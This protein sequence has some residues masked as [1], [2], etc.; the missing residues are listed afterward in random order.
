MNYKEVEYEVFL[1]NKDICKIRNCSPA[2]AT[3]ILKRI[4]LLYE[5]DI[6][7]LPYPHCVP[8]SAYDAFYGKHKVIRIKKDV[9]PDQGN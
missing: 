2:T 1:Q 5:I 4:R 9:Y 7:R 3:R 6:D 8:K